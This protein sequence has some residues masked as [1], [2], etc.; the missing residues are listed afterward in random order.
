MDR[1]IKKTHN[2]I[3]GATVSLLSEKQLKDISIKEICNKAD[4]SRSTFYLH[5]RD[6]A[7][8]LEQ[9][10]NN[11]SISVTR[12]LDNV[13]FN[14]FIDSPYLFLDAVIE[15]LNEDLP[16]YQLLM[17]NQYHTNFR[18]RLKNLLVNRVI[19]NHKYRVKNLL[20]FEYSINFLMTGMIETICDNIEDL[21]NE[22]KNLLISTLNK[23]ITTGFKLT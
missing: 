9:L 11:I 15:F 20:E 7:D 12:I 1:R 13:N 4:V 6:A 17:K 23:Q 16:L 21:N 19:E 22:N 14:E 18:R 3:I 5:Y 8:V 2:A 10:Y